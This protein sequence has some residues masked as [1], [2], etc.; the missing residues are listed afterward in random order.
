MLYGAMSIVTLACSN[1]KESEKATEVSSAKPNIILIYT[2]DVGFGDLSVYG[3]KI[4]TPNIDKLAA[5]GLLFTNAYATAATC[6]PSRYSLLTGEYAWRAKG[7]GVAPGDASALIRPGVE[8]LPSVL[9]RAG[10]RTAAVGKW[11]L[12]L[13]GDEGPDW[14]GE[15]NPG[16]L[17]IGFDYSFIIPATGDRVPTVFVEDHHIV[18]L[19]PSD[20]IEVN[21]RKKIGD[22]PTGKDNPELLK[23]MWS[24]G[25]NHSIVNGVSR[26]GYQTGGEAALWRDEDFA[27]TFVD[28]AAAFIKKESDK[29]FFVY[30]S[31]HDIHVPRIAHEQFQ[32]ATDF[33]PRGDV[34]VQLD[35]QVGELMKLLTE[36]G[37]EENTMV[38][39]SSDNGPVL[40]DG[41]V[42]QAVELKADHVQ[43]GGLRGG[44]YSAFE[45]GTRIP[46]IVKW[47]SI[48]TAN[49]RTDVMFSQVDFLGSIAAKMEIPYDTIQ[50]VDTENHWGV[51]IG[52]ESTGRASLV[53][54]ALFSNLAYLR[55][56]GMKFIPGNNG[57]DM[58]P[59]GPIIETGFAKT[60]QLFDIRTD[61]KELKD[62]SAAH[63]SVV[64]EMKKELSDIV[65]NK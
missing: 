1:S 31:T 15:L 18:G 9:Q 52:K 62:I 61:P 26:I 37:L 48:V 8:T 56:D 30:F 27:Q 39:F 36:Q 50:A 13:G 41:Y 10:Y 3:G 7:R 59:W 64:E 42:D 51:L 19:D 25:H 24:H 63:P 40:D 46:M 6:T 53:Q 16:P 60:D 49:S 34:I 35:W 65:N 32:G 12:G 54:E 20:P 17:E 14:N 38:I 57:P 2:D 4:A 28:K 43:G 23:M 44:K 11:H 29:P 21:Y 55:S 58:V 45:A 5:D 33:G 22:G 47:P